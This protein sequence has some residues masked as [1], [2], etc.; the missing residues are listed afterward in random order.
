MPTP[1]IKQQA[2]SAYSILFD[3]FAVANAQKNQFGMVKL[4]PIP[5]KGGDEVE[6]FLD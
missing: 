2:P 5:E 6:I 1:M 3:E 4:C